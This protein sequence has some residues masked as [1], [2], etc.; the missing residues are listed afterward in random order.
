MS[1]SHISEGPSSFTIYATEKHDVSKIQIGFDGPGQPDC[2]LNTKKDQ[3]IEVTYTASVA[4][5]YQIHVRYEDKAVPGSPFKCK[6]IGDVKGAVGKMKASGD[7]K[8]GKL[9]ATNTILIDGREVGILGMFQY[10]VSQLVQKWEVGLIYIKI[11]P[12]LQAASA[13]IW[14]GKNLMSKCLKS[15]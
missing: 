4:G 3:S 12:F 13:Q 6:I 15:C 8:E 10:V 2:K 9:N 11:M 1:I 7:T 14:R 5:D